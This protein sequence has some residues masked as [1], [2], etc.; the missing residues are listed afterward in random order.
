MQAPLLA[1]EFLGLNDSSWSQL[2]AFDPLPL[3]EKGPR[4][5]QEAAPQKVT[6]SF[7]GQSAR[8]RTSTRARA[9]ARLRLGV[10]GGRACVCL[11]EGARSGGG[12]EPY[13]HRLYSLKEPPITFAHTR[14]RLSPAH[15]SAQGGSR[16]LFLDTFSSFLGI[17]MPELI[18]Y[19]ALLS[20]S[21]RSVWLV[22][23]RRLRRRARHVREVSG[24]RQR[25]G[26]GGGGGGEEVVVERR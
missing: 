12:A 11:L 20:G 13:E 14:P 21:S 19:L 18:S 4:Q 2:S 8:R 17:L 9:L 16:T 1:A 10:R 3:G 5:Y 7:Y 26:G 6:P 23:E 15:S 22:D 24:K 25:G